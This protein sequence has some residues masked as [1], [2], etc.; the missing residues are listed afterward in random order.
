MWSH[1]VKVFRDNDHSGIPLLEGVGSS[2]WREIDS[3]AIDGT[4]LLLK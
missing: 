3:I 2:I 1:P 4:T